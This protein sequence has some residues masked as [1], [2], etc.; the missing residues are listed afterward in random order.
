[1]GGVFR[2]IFRAPAKIFGKITGSTKAKKKAKKRAAEQQTQI[3]QLQAAAAT[4]SSSTA[5]KRRAALGSGYGTS[6][7]TIMT[8]VGGIEEQAKT[9][10]TVLGG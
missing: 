3:A 5:T 10:K 9:S 7:Q 4:P 6:G 1:M 2:A 8:G